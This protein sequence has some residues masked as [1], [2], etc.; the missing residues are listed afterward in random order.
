MMN[1][2]ERKDK[3]KLLV[4]ILSSSISLLSSLASWESQKHMC[5][6]APK[7]QMALGCTEA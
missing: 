1:E 6:I 3:A 4:R 5:L 2:K 7:A